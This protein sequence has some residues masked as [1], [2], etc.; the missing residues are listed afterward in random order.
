VRAEAE[1]EVV[2]GLDEKMLHLTAKL[3]RQFAERAKLEAMIREN[4]EGGFWRIV[5]QLLKII[6]IFGENLRNVLCNIKCGPY[7][8]LIAN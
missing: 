2:V 4:A 1:E 7:F 3:E 6:M 8:L 5:R